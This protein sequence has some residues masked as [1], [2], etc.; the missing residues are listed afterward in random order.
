[1]ETIPIITPSGLPYKSKVG[2]ISPIFANIDEIIFPSINKLA[3][4]FVLSRVFDHI[5]RTKKIRPKSDYESVLLQWYRQL[6]K[7]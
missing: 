1:M 3:T 5:G 6:D 4:A 2:K 7:Q